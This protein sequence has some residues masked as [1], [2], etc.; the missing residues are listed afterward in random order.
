[1]ASFGFL[2][3]A[4]DV[5][6]GR[7]VQRRGNGSSA[8]AFAATPDGRRGVSGTQFGRLFLWDLDPLRRRASLPHQEF[9]QNSEVAAVAITPDG[10]RALSG[11]N[12][13]MIRAWDLST[14]RCLATFIAEDFTTCAC[15]AGNDVFL[16]GSRNGAVHV[17]KVMRAPAAAGVS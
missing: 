1:M 9:G 12:D 2:I 8:P 7:R 17:L 6:T 4:W 13:R 16:A 5:A 11:G 15:A 14:R 3:Y 10:R